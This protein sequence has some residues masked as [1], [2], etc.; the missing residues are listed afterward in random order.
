VGTRVSWLTIRGP[1]VGHGF[2]EILRV[3]DEPLVDR[4]DPVFCSDPLTAA[5][6][7]LGFK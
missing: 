1:E 6:K 7:S 2:G 5:L 4:V 3:F